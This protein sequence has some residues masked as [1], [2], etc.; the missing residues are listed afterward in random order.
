[1][2]ARRKSEDAMSPTSIATLKQHLMPKQIQAMSDMS[3]FTKGQVKRTIL[4]FDLR[5]DPKPSRRS[6]K[7][8][9]SQPPNSTWNG[10]T[11]KA[12]STIKASHKGPGISA[13]GYL[14]VASSMKGANVTGT[15]FKR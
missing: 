6:Y 10:S 8:N 9:G 15:P 5:A 2:E 3:L 1:M 13:N 14:G 12:N 4:G 7:M 11:L